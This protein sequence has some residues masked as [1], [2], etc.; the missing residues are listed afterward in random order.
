M[1]LQIQDYN[2]LKIHIGGEITGGEIREVA[3]LTNTELRIE[4][5]RLGN[6]AVW[7]ETMKELLESA[8]AQRRA[9]QPGE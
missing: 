9:S 2:A 5:E 7:C 4:I 1:G 6:R 3:S 8:L